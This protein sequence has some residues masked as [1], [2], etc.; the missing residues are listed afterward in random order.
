MSSGAMIWAALR[1]ARTL[2]SGKRVATI[3]P[4]SGGR[5]LSTEL[6]EQSV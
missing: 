2:G 3:A 6:F 5:Y 4:D 1:M